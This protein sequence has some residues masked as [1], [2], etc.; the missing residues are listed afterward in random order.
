MTEVSFTYAVI[1]FNEERTINRCLTSIQKNVDKNDE[2]IVIDT[3]STDK[4]LQIL[5]VEFPNVKVY[6]Y[7]W[8]DD[9]SQARNLA[10]KVAKCNWIFFVDSDEVL[11]KNCG[12][13]TK[14][15]I[16]TLINIGKK[17]FVLALKIVN[18]NGFITYNSGRI[19]PN[20]KD[21]YFFGVVHEY[22]IYKNNIH[23]NN[24]DTITLND[25][26]VYHD[27]YKPEIIKDKNKLKRNSLLDK[28]M[29]EKL[30]NSI[31]YNYFYYRDSKEL[32]DKTTY[33][34]GM[35]KI[36]DNNKKNIFTIYATFAI[37][38]SY[39]KEKNFSEAENFIEK[40]SELINVLKIPA[41]KW[42]LA[43]L[44]S[45]SDFSK[46]QADEINLRA[47]LIAIK[48]NHKTDLNEIF[49]DGINY[50]ELIGLI[51]LSIGN[52]EEAVLIDNNMRKKRFNSL[53]SCKLCEYVKNLEKI[54]KVKK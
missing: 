50:D 16:N 31:R 17:Q 36:L 32:I 45:L 49:K 34:S 53:L 43:Y 10:I 20:N 47:T 4:T 33:I 21:F 52:I 51:D 14:K 19:L 2:I 46:L 44:A 35:K 1:C 6:H 48:E 54:E 24:Y 38:Q 29:L 37:I 3:G 15:C 30:P 42:Q 28:K 39:I 25:V 26:I 18:Y 22:P 9:F 12:K 7:K 13:T 23:A 5:S 41:L 8:K 11:S 40:A 27:G